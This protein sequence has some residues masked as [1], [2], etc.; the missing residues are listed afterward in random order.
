MICPTCLPL[1]NCTT[2]AYAMDK[3]VDVQGTEWGG[4]LSDG[5]TLKIGG[6]CYQVDLAASAVEGP[7]TIY[8]E[9][10]EA[11]YDDCDD[12]VVC[13]CGN[14]GIQCCFHDTA[15]NVTWNEIV[16]GSGSGS[17]NNVPLDSLSGYTWYQESGSTLCEYEGEPPITRAT[18]VVGVN[19][20]C[21]GGEDERRWSLH[22]ERWDGCDAT[23]MQD[24]AMF[25]DGRL[26]P[27]AAECGG[28]GTACDQAGDCCGITGTFG[29][30][31]SSD[32]WIY[33]VEITIE[34]VGGQHECGSM[35]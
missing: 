11:Q 20:Q 7:P 10:V 24:W 2:Q 21:S 22:V 26:E 31:D 34:V 19:F 32:N 9:D 13:T 33:A 15:V 23:F 12:C 28:A 8:P 35:P 25:A 6:V 27:H 29:Y 30:K 4:G 5:Y 3:I 16:G 14:S 1:K 18:L 17:A